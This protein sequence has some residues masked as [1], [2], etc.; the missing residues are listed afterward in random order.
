M[1]GAI[2]ASRHPETCSARH[3]VVSLTVPQSIQSG[4]GAVQCEN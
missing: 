1:I 3:D 4:V 2:E